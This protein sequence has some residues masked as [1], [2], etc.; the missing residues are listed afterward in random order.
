MTHK[1]RTQPYSVRVLRH[2]VDF[3]PESEGVCTGAIFVVD[4][5]GPVTFHNHTLIFI[6]GAGRPYFIGSMCRGTNGNDS[7]ITDADPDGDMFPIVGVTTCVNSACSTCVFCGVISVEVDAVTIVAALTGVNVLAFK[8]PF[9][10][11]I[12]GRWPLAFGETFGEF[13]ILVDGCDIVAAV[14]VGID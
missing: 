12:A 8:H 4:D 11:A 10:A 1:R 3:T 5:L 2:S 6:T 9:F 13:T 14:R 7:A